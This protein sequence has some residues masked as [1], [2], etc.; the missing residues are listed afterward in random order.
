MEVIEV[1]RA[2]MK[3]GMTRWA[4]FGP[5]QGLPWEVAFSCGGKIRVR[6]EP[7][8]YDEVVLPELMSLLDNSEIATWMDGEGKQALLRQDGS[9]VGEE[10][11]WSAHTLGLARQHLAERAET[12]EIETGD[13]KLLLRSLTKPNRLFIVGA[14]H[15]AVH[16]VSIARS[17]NYRAIVHRSTGI[18]RPSG[19]FR[20]SAPSI[21]RVLAG[22]GPC[23]LR[24]GRN[25]L[26]GH[27]DA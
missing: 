19:A 1:A 27:A 23:R 9:L 14:V 18:L 8:E 13:G 22:G 24:V 10:S 5:S 4:E 21:D 16:L 20:G 7:F 3:D 15:I 11:Q 26:R 6:I 17:L 25:G 2:C 12:R